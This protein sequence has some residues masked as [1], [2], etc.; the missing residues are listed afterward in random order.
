MDTLSDPFTRIFTYAALVSGATIALNPLAGSKADLDATVKHIRPTVIVASTATLNSLLAG[1]TRAGIWRE[2]IH[3]F[4]CRTLE[5]GRIPK[6]NTSRLRMVFSAEAAGGPDPH[7][8]SS[9][10]LNDL[11]VLLEAKVV[12]GLKHHM[13]AGPITQQNAY[14]YRVQKQVPKPDKVNGLDK[15]SAHFGGVAPSCEVFTRDWMEYKASDEGGSRG[16]IVVRGST[17]MGEE[18]DLGVT[19]KWQ[20]EGVLSYA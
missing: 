7:P 13:V 6:G 4:R 5:S 3:Y 15:K 14:D 18:V 2:L 10:D 19:G 1:T 8:L 11:R 17:A 12:Y 20:P 16:R 9:E